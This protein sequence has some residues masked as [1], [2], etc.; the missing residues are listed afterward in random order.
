MIKYFR[1]DTITIPLN[2]RSNPQT[3]SGFVDEIYQT[4]ETNYNNYEFLV[5]IS[6]LTSKNIN[7]DDI[8]NYALNKTHG[9]IYNFYSVYS[10][11]N[12]DDKNAYQFGFLHI[13]CSY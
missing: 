3:L 8:N 4:L 6:I 7:V 10:I 1:E 9:T 5:N 11:S 2:L 13:L 12:E